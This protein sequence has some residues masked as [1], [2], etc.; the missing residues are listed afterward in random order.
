MKY[1]QAYESVRRAIHHNHSV[2]IVGEPEIGKT[3]LLK[4]LADVL[5]MDLVVSTPSLWDPTDAKG[6]PFP[7]HQNGK[8]TVLPFDQMHRLINAKKET[9]WLIDDIGQ[10]TT[11]VQAALM[12]WILERENEGQRLSDHVHIVA[13][14]NDRKHRAGVQGLLETVKSR[15]NKI[16]TLEPCYQHWR[17][18]FALKANVHHI[19]MAFLDFHDRLNAQNLAFNNFQPTADLT[20]SPSPRTWASASKIINAAEKEGFI[21]ELGDVDSVLFHDVCGAIGQTTASELWSFARKASELPSSIEEVFI[22]PHGCKI[23]SSLETKFILVSSIVRSCKVENV[24]S[25]TEFAKRLYAEN[26]EIGSALIRTLFMK[27]DFQNTNAFIEMST[28]PEYGRIFHG[29]NVARA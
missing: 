22:N 10:A 5:D 15:F 12:P 27:S 14:T 3:S 13:A 4:T 23:P 6:L 24:S 20:N 29:A 11:S 25:A 16:I 21:D 18:A 28:H 9:I 2:L 19:V 1:P 8:T 17:N 7:D 26:E